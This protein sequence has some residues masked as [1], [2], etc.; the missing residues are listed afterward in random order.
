MLLAAEDLRLNVD[1]LDYGILIIYFAVVIGIGVL[2]RRSI[3]TSE[4][5]FLSGRALPAGSPQD[6]GFRCSARLRRFG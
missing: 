1:G 4:D 2:A 3:A 5:F 6:S